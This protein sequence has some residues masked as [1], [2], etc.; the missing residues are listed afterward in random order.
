MNGVIGIDISTDTNRAAAVLVIER[1]GEYL[2][3]ELRTPPVRDQPTCS[4]CGRDQPELLRAGQTLRFL[5]RDEVC[6]GCLADVA[7]A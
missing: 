2:E 5:C 1:P 3:Y 6:N 4:V 7:A